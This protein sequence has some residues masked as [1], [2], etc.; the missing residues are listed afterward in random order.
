MKKKIIIAIAMIVVLI[1]SFLIGTGFMK[2]PNAVLGEYTVSEDGS[3]ITLSVRVWTSMGYIRDFKDNGG[4]IKP[5]YLTFYSTFGGLNS[6]LGSKRGVC[7][8]IC[9][10]IQQSV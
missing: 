3:E 1:T 10:C 6:S 5:H 7:R 4:G 9:E 2:N 8:L